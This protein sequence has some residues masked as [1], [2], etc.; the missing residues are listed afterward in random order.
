[1]C[2]IV[3]YVGPRPAQ[4]VVVEGLRRLEYRGYDSAGVAVIGVGGQ[5]QVAKK[6]GRANAGVMFNLCH[7]L[8]V[9][10]EQNLK[11]V[12]EAALPGRV[13]KP[14]YWVVV[15]PVTAVGEIGYLVMSIH[16]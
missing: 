4:D 1:M 6:A 12:L 9:D 15:R 8:K 16:T 2:G 10:D 7:W 3:G 11:P 14:M 5:L 13:W